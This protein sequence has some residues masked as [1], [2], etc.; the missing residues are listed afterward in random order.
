MSD[1]TEEFG[2]VGTPPATAADADKRHRF[3][4]AAIRTGAIMVLLIL[5]N[6]FT[7]D[8]DLWF[9]W[10]V[11]GLAFLLVFLVLNF[12]ISFWNAYSCGSYLTESKI[13]GGWFRFVVWCG[14]VM[15]ACGFTWVILTIL[16]MVA[17]RGHASDGAFLSAFAGML[18]VAPPVAVGHVARSER[19]ALLALGPDHWLVIA[20][21]GQG[22][23]LSQKLNLA[24]LGAHAA[25]MVK[26]VRAFLENPYERLGA[27]P[28]HLGSPAVAKG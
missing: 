14:L 21:P 19:Y 28:D 2:P 13:I 1:V 8:G 7:W 10:P 23:E 9:H 6:L 4:V 15:A 22:R 24:F 5:I 3:K 26:T 17:V 12:G 16:T 18:G 27:I 11:M 20:E 25:A